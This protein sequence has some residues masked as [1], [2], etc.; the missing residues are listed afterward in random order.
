MVSVEKLIRTGRLPDGRFA[1]GHALSRGKANGLRMD[2]LRRRLLSAVRP[3][4]IEAIGRRLCD[5]AANGDMQ[6]IKMLLDYCVGKAPAAVELSGPGGKA[7]GGIELP[8][9]QQAIL[10]ALA[11]F[12]EARIAV[13]A[14]LRE[15]SLDDSAERADSGTGPGGDDGGSALRP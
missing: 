15:L 3:E 6:A 1:P 12:A 8:Q 13:A 7:F 4:T 14:R 9:V 2:K 10:A 5:L 11:P